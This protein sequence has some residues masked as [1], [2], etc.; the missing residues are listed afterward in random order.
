MKKI[1]IAAIL[2]GLL[3]IVVAQNAAEKFRALRYLPQPQDFSIIVAFDPMAIRAAIEDEISMSIDEETNYYAQFLSELSPIAKDFFH[4]WKKDA[5][6]VYGFDMTSYVIELS[7]NY[8]YDRT[9]EKIFPIRDGLQAGK[10]VEGLGFQKI[11]EKKISGKIYS[12]YYT[13]LYEVVLTEDALIL[14]SIADNKDISPQNNANERISSIAKIYKNPS[15]FIKTPAY[16]LFTEEFAPIISWDK[17]NIKRISL[18]ENGTGTITTIPNTKTQYD[19]SS[20]PPIDTTLLAYCDDFFVYS[21]AKIKDSDWISMHKNP[22]QF[23]Q[24]FKIPV[25]LK[26]IFSQHYF[27]EAVECEE[28]GASL[29]YPKTF[30]SKYVSSEDVRKKIETWILDSIVSSYHTHNKKNNTE[31]YIIHSDQFPFFSDDDGRKGDLYLA[32]R[33]E[34]IL[35][36]ANVEKFLSFLLNEPDNHHLHITDEIRQAPFY[37]NIEGCDGDYVFWD[38]PMEGKGYVSAEGHLVIMGYSFCGF[39]PGWQSPLFYDWDW[40][41]LK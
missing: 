34:Y 25:T 11:L 28:G 18:S 4:K 36:T 8:Y 7:H 30:M 21:R 9:E 2:S 41:F 14:R 13:G 3:G 20:L 23:L 17:N 35:L 10:F 22:D 19:I 29:F 39:C 32:F 26:E 6:E 24:D 15:S 5:T 12:Y 33:D 16:T 38:P 37:F 40:G 31:Y 27:Y 1:F